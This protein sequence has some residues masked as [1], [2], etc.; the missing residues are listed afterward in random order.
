MTLEKLLNF[1]YI[2]N[3]QQLI[4]QTIKMNILINLKQ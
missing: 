4:D 3:T 1:K 2:I